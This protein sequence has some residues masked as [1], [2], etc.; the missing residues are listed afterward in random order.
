MGHF[1]QTFFLIVPQNTMLC[2]RVKNP[3][4]NSLPLTDFPEGVHSGALDLISCP[5][6]KPSGKKTCFVLIFHFLNEVHLKCKSIPSQ[7][8]VTGNDLYLAV[9]TYTHT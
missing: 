6:E 9:C 7:K 2:R 3:P 1:A 8:Q 5:G 4:G